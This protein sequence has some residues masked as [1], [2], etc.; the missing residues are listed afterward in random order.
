MER[1]LWAFSQRFYDR[2][3]GVQRLPGGTVV[4]SDGALS[5]EVLTVRRSEYQPQS[6]FFRLGANVL[7][8]PERSALT[9]G[10]VA[11]LRQHRH[12]PASD[13]DHFF[14]DLGGREP[15]RLRH[16]GWGPRF[17]RRYF[18]DLIANDRPDEVQRVIDDLLDRSIVPDD[19]R[20]RVFGT[21]RALPDIDDRLTMA[22]SVAQS[23]SGAPTDL[24]GM[25]T[26]RDITLTPRQRAELFRR[27]IL[28]FVG[29]LG[30]ALEWSILLAAGRA[31]SD[32]TAV[33]HHVAEALRLY[34]PAWR[35]LRVAAAPHSLGRLQINAGDAVLTLTSA[36]HRSSEA[37]TL[38]NS[39][40]P[41][42]WQGAT[43]GR[44]SYYLPFGKGP[45]MCPA[46]VDAL[47]MLEHCTSQIV[48]RYRIEVRTRPGSKPRVLTLMAPPLGSTVLTPKD[49]QRA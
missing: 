28:S 41:L 17:V 6:G 47:A 15:I 39:Y 33:K 8:P 30:V 46:R 43:S 37:W 36:I 27:L 4:V 44:G 18:A 1:N 40:R 10:L 34:P 42:R 48:A 31:W 24:F 38:P 20:G 25:L 11:L 32:D 22:F 45:E 3:Q 49:Y 2:A 14:R 7:Q 12:A 26:T 13:S 16:Q 23:R 9:H 21:Y 19:I 29:F 5:H 35:L